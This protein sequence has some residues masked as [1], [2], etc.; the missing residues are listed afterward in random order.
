MSPLGLVS[1][2]PW[3]ERGPTWNTVGQWQH[4]LVVTFPLPIHYLVIH[5]LHSINQVHH[6]FLKW[7]WLTSLGWSPLRE[8]H[9][10]LNIKGGKKQDTQNIHAAE[11]IGQS[12]LSVKIYSHGMWWWGHL[13]NLTTCF[14]EQL[15]L[16]CRKTTSKAGYG[17]TPLYSQQLRSWGRMAKILFLQK[18]RE[19]RREAPTEIPRPFEWDCVGNM[20]HKVSVSGL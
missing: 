10:I 15:W 19:G 17:G 14:E 5:G 1:W 13:M 18:E 16:Q 12:S 6:Q 11:L 4:Y 20:K 2:S 7:A 9:N 8:G 3:L